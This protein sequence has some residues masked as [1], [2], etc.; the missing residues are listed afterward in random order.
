M[1]R[2][3]ARLRLGPVVEQAHASCTPSQRAR[4]V[5]LTLE[6]LA[7]RFENLSADSTPI[8]DEC[9]SELQK[10]VAHAPELI[11]SAPSVEQ[12]SA[13]EFK[14]LAAA[15]GDV[16]PEDR[17][18][19]HRSAQSMTDDQRLAAVPPGVEIKDFSGIE[20]PTRELHPSERVAQHR[21]AN[22]TPLRNERPVIASSDV[23]AFV[24][25]SQ[26]DFDSMSLEFRTNAARRL[27]AK[28]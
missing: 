9:L 18:R 21:A 12:V 5:E 11:R 22:P 24:G 6:A 26:A 10:V 25:L 13:F 23:A 7:K 28:K 8:A 19:A 15:K 14:K 20:P 27:A 17:I 4:L 3:A 1:N 2:D 16:T